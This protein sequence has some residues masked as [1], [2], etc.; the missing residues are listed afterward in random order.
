MPPD[1]T[2]AQQLRLLI[3]PSNDNNEIMLPELERDGDKLQ[4]IRR[5]I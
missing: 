2:V 5:L 3:E 1:T 4:I